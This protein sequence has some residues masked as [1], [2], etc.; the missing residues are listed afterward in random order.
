VHY[1]VDPQTERIDYAAVEAIARE[2]RPK[3]IIAGYS[4]YPWV[5]DWPRFRQIAEAV[6]AYLFADIA[7][8]AGMVAAQVVASPV[9]IADVITFT[10]HKSLCGPRGAVILTTSPK[11]AKAIDRAVFPGEQGGPHVNTMLA[12]A[13]AFRL[14]ATSAFRR[15]QTEIVRNCIA[16]SDRLERATAHQ[17]RRHRN[18]YDQCRL[19]IGAGAGRDA[20]FGGPGGAYPGFGRDR[21][22]PQ[23][24]PRRSNRRRSFRHP[25]GNAVD[26]PARL[27]PGA[28]G[29][30]GRRHCRSVAGVPAPSASRAQGLS[31]AGAHRFR[32]PQS[33]P[34]Q[35]RSFCRRR[36]EVEVERHGYPHF[37]G[38]DD[39][40]PGAP[41]AE[42]E[43]VGAESEALLRWATSV[44]TEDLGQGETVEMRLVSPLDEIRGTLGRRGPESWSLVVPSGQASLALT[45]LRDLSDGFVA[46][47]ADDPLK[48]SPGPAIVRLVGGTPA[49]PAARKIADDKPWYIGVTGGGGAALPAF[50]WRE[51]ADRP[52]RRT[53]LFET[54]RRLGAKMV[55]FAG[56][57]MPVWYT[58]VID[59]HVATRTAAGLFDVSHMGVYQAEGAQAAPFLDSVFTNDVAGLSVGE[60][61]YTQLL[62]PS[63]AVLDDAMIYRRAEQA[64]LIVVNASNDDKDWA[65]LE[66]VRQGKVSVD[67]LRPGSKAYGLGVTLLNLRDPKAGR[68]Q[69]VDLALQGPRSLEVLL[70]LGADASSEARLRALPWAGVTEVILG[71]VDLVV[72]RTGYTGE[73]IAFELFVHPEK[74]APLWQALMQAGAPLGPPV[75]LGARD[76]LRTEAGL[77]LYGNEMGGAHSLGVGDAGFATYVKTYKPWFVGRQ[78]FLRQEAERQGE[79]T[80]FRFNEKGVRMA[81]SGDPVVDQRGKVIGFVTS[82]A[83]DRE[84][85]LLGLAHLE[86]KALAEG[87]AIGIFQGGYVVAATPSGGPRAGDRLTVPTAATVLSRFATGRP[88]RSLSRTG[89]LASAMQLG[90]WVR[91]S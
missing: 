76:S 54:H 6:G 38:L 60:S 80:R 82:C 85:Y 48:K 34:S 46:M 67:T 31:A 35:S 47:D 30:V 14:A 55:P 42:V 44:R 37:Y 19:P 77:P 89:L 86:R 61:H 88:K 1:G 26:Y 4:S 43:I 72:S 10:T 59:E 51:P 22:Q 63:G 39:I 8:I 66:A 84:G 16:L 13:V 50:T 23:H 56:W 15:L 52:L 29:R 74:S 83:V 62:D 78:A 17:L 49:L 9:G 40:A 24:H 18:P 3:V 69:R 33:D 79:V 32:R 81:H 57:E 11:L 58:S 12:Q 2:H 65:W 41:F 45:W 5:P 25:P 90:D 71:G 87:T 36:A 53:A 28:H 73:R 21:R 91:S 7:H 20:A 70:A 64:Y 27:R 68:E 75:G